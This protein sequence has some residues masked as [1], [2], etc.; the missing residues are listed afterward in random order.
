MALIRCPECQN[1]VSDKATSCPHCGFP[2]SK[3]E[4]ADKIKSMSKSVW[5]FFRKIPRYIK[6]F[7][8][9]SILG[10]ILC[11]I[12]FFIVGSAI[13]IALAA[14]MMWLVNETHWGRYV[15]YPV[16][17]VGFHIG[18]YFSFCKWYNGVLG[19]VLFWG[20]VIMEIVLGIT[21]VDKFIIGAYV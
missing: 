9:D 3:A 18:G 8:A 1:N 12:V 4:K 21:Y 15:V 17:F 7:F 6:S 2:L 16:F 11:S 10:I 5:G 20:V 13:I 19:K 14:L